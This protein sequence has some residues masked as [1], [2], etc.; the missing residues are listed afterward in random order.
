M[1]NLYRSILA[2]LIFI[3]TSCYNDV[4]EVERCDGDVE[5]KLHGSIDQEYSTRVDDSGFAN[6]DAMGVYIVDYN[7]GVAGQITDSGLRASN[8]IYTYDAASNTWSTNSSVYWRDTTTP[9]DI[10]GYYPAVMAIT[11]PD[12]YTFEVSDRQNGT[13]NG[14]VII[15]F[16]S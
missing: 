1:R 13:S 3:C 15:N 5:L 14:S 12:K 10:Y 9:V 16:R 2:F 7:D 11:S 8:V 4:V 6:G